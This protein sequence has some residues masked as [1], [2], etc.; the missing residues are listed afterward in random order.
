LIRWVPHF[1]VAP[2][3]TDDDTARPID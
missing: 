2:R 3:R 1:A